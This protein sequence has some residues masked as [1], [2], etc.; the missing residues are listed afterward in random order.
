[1]REIKQSYAVVIRLQ[2]IK[3]SIYDNDRDTALSQID[4]MIKQ[5]TEHEYTCER[6]G[7]FINEVDYHCGGELCEPCSE[8]V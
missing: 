7:C 2:E 4:D 8:L 5:I 6:C 3:K 1:M